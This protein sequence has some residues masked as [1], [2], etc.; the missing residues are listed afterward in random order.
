MDRL[1]ELEED[2]GK[3]TNVIAVFTYDVWSFGCIMFELIIS[4]KFFQCRTNGD[5]FD[6]EKHRLIYYN[7]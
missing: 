5:I 6:K 7:F 1:E 4:K 3:S 2:G